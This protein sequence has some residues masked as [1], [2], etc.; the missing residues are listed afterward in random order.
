MTDRAPEKRE[1]IGVKLPPRLVKRLDAFRENQPAA[2]TRTA[3][4]QA[5]IEFFL[6]AHEPKKKR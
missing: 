6:D 4:I 3:V 5:A 2:P 1:Q